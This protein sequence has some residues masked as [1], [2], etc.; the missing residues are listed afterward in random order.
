MLVFTRYNLVLGIPDE[1]FM[2]GTVLMQSI[3]LQALWVPCMV[4]LS[5]MCPKNMEATLF[6]LM[7]GC[8]NIGSR[9]AEFFGAALLDH[10]GVTPSGN[11]NES[12][13]FENLWVV[14]LIAAVVP[15][16]TIF[17]V[18]F[19]VPDATQT[20]KILDDDASAVDGSPFKRLFGE[21]TDKSAPNEASALN[22]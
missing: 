6:A 5:H 15:L 8:A 14:A 21:K 19:M 9:I 13:K 22:A 10:Y 20:E 7:A 12:H 1:V 4:M 3:F 18:P 16:I 17:M 2:V 11:K